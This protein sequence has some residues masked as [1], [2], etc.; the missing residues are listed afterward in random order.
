[1]K[2]YFII[3]VVFAFGAVTA[4]SQSRGAGM[5][6]MEVGLGVVNTPSSYSDLNIAVTRS[7]NSNFATFFDYNLVS[8]KNIINSHVFDAKIGPYFKL[9]R[10]FLVAG[11]IGLGGI[12][13]PSAG[14]GSDSRLDM[15]IPLQVK[16]S[17][18][19]T[20]FLGV[21]VKGTYYKMFN[22]DVSDHS[23]LVFFASLNF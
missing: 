19:V 5:S 7:I 20:S 21:G 22:K 9:N 8:K 13:S 23:N 15:D 11:S 17:M 3:V 10:N 14:A 18:L 16:G 1:M 6:Y 12:F 2:R 4:F